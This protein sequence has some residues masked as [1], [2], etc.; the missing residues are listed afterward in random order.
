M[1]FNFGVFFLS[2]FLSETGVDFGRSVGNLAWSVVGFINE[3]HENE[4]K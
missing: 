2:F 3:N 1:W 4:K